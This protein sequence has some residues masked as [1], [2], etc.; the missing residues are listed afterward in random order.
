[1]KQYVIGAAVGAALMV[2]VPV[3]AQPRAAIPP[4]ALHSNV[5]TDFNS[6]V[7]SPTVDVTAYIHPQAAV[8]GN[9]YLGKRVMVAPQAAIRG[10]EGQPIY[11]SD[12]ANVQDGVVLHALETEHGGHVVDKNLMDVDGKKFAVWIGKRVTMAH[13]S[14]VHGPAVV[15]DNTFVGM[16]AL[17]FKARVGKNCVLEPRALLLGVTVPDGRYVPTGMVVT[18]QADANNLPEIT[19]D[20]PFKTLND[21][22]IHV[23]THLAEGYNHMGPGH[24]TTAEPR[25]R[26]RRAAQH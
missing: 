19:D 2:V 25:R 8:I 1:M 26:R 16:Q 14:Q 18:K 7:E 22:V 21:G 9:V 13:Q 3:L 12:D 17:I 24:G 20:Y 15:G 6:S 11:I 10:D 23:N 4:D 5:K